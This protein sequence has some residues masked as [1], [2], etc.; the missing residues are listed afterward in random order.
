MS[1]SDYSGARQGVSEADYMPIG[2]LRALQLERLQGLVR[3]VYERVPLTRRRM[4]E[5]GVRPEHIRSLED[6]ALLPFMMK[7]D[8]RDEYPFGLFASP[9]EEIVRF[10]C[11]SGTTGKPIVIGSTQGD[12]RVWQEGCMRALAM[13]GVTREDVVQ[14]AYG[15]GLFTGG[16]GLHYGAE[17]LGCAVL[18]IS[19]GNTE[20]QLMLMRDFGV[21]VI[22]CTPSYFLHLVDEGMKRGIDF[23]R[24]MRLRHGV[25]GAEPWTEAM[26]GK[27]EQ[28]TGITAHDIY[29]LTEISGPGVAN[30]CPHRRGLHV[31]ED[32]FYPEIIDPD[33]LEPL[34]DG[35]RG[36]LVF[37]TLT[38]RGTPM[39]RYRTRDLSLIH[40]EPCPCGRT[41]RTFERIS[42]R[43]DDMLI[44]RGV[45]LFP[46]QIETA[47]LSVDAVL[48]HY[49]IFVSKAGDL[50]ML[51]IKVEVTAQTLSDDIKSLENLR[52]RIA[53]AIQR[54]INISA[55]VTLAEPHSLPRSE[56]KLCRVTDLR[57]G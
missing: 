51:E 5:R 37:T 12:I 20:R 13:C 16:L 3:H 4:D 19:G 29:G 23:R 48:P 32:H 1:L 26:R 46:S 22:A 10:H 18:P 8:L 35:E 39:L 53:H 7:S 52:A 42:A 9:Q 14:V 30:D 43:T 34:P 57:N 33:T 31:F 45:N 54:V 38:R 50:D 41:I 25:F 55:K 17:G 28:L 11:S 24:D 49:H 47:L 36:E 6:I 15:Y 56:G 2:Q 40:S 44:I 21:T 27:I